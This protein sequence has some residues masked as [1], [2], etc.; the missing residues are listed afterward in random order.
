MAGKQFAQPIAATMAP[1]APAPLPL[2]EAIL[3]A[4]SVSISVFIGDSFLHGLPELARAAGEHGHTFVECRG[5]KF[6][7]FNSG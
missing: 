4:L 3:A 1:I 2:L 6:Q 5:S 7:T